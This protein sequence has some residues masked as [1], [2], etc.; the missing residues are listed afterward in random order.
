MPKGMQPIFS[1]TLSSTSTITFNNIPQIYTSLLLIGKARS[2]Y[3]SGFA[4]AYVWFQDGSGTTNY[5]ATAANGNSST[6]SSYRYT[7]SGTAN[8][9][10]MNGAAHTA[11]AFTSFKVSFPNYRDGQFKHMIGESS[12][13]QDGASVNCFN[14]GQWRST[15]PITQINM[16][17]ANAFVAGSVFTLYGITRA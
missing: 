10:A 1:Q 14:A 16:T 11:N 3:A 12:A 9:F 17:V 13:Q 15:S 7:S 8:M 4:D 5:S 6:V 2:A